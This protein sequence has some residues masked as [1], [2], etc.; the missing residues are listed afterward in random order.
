MLLAGWGPIGI[1]VE[2][3]LDE[4]WLCSSDEVKGVTGKYFTYRGER[5]AA[6]SAY[7]VKERQRLW[8]ILAE[9][10]PEEAKIWDLDWL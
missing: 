7:D 8:S 1:D 2:S 9:L 5:S 4:T 10:A 3:A 6:R